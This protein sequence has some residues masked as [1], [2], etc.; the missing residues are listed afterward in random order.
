MN[1]LALGWLVA[2]AATWL[3]L[4]SLSERSLPFTMFL[5]GPRWVVLLPLIFLV[6]AALIW[7]RS[8]LLVLAAGA[9]IAVGPI[10]GFRLSSSVLRAD[11]RAPPPTPL[12]GI[13]RVLSFNS[14][15][16]GGVRLHLDELIAT[17]SP[18][19]MAFQECGSGIA[20]SL[21]DRAGWHFAQ[22]Q[23]LCVL[24]RWA[25]VRS[26]TM[27]RAAFERI[28]ELGYGGSA[29]VIRYTI[30]HPRGNF[31]LVNLHLETPRRGLAGILGD[32]G[33]LND[34]TGL[35]NF[36]RSID[37]DRFSV[38]AEIRS[39]ESERASYWSARHADATPIVVA[40]DFNMPVESSIFRRYW[41]VLKDAFETRGNGFGYSKHEGSLLHARIDHILISPRSFEVRGAWVLPD[42]GS[43]HRPVMADLKYRP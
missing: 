11:G 20:R 32:D 12:D 21:A 42:A 28:S 29:T 2:M 43:D 18:S 5:Y 35:P 31:D 7:S 17:N 9:W 36:P 37:S 34:Q 10:M 22:Y 38:N 3:G 19:V 15:G 23:S 27:P 39:R 14:Q 41:R 16:G 26:D 6:P 24:S 33:L 25:V 13:V 4:I 30:A 40:G 1:R 8:S